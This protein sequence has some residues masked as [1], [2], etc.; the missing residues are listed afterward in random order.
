[1]ICSF[2][3]ENEGKNEQAFRFPNLPPGR[4]GR[5]G[6]NCTRVKEMLESAHEKA[7]NELINCEYPKISFNKRLQTRPKPKV[8]S[9]HMHDVGHVLEFHRKNLSTESGFKDACR[10]QPEGTGVIIEEFDAL[11]EHEISVKIDD[12]VQVQNT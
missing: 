5:K 9:R 7:S 10:V 12:Q 2:D 11:Y 3:E 4:G 1:M 6:K 8:V